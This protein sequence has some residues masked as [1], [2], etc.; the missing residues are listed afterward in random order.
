MHEV[1]N[2]E[3]IKIDNEPA[4]S[5]EEIADTGDEGYHLTASLKDIRSNI[6]LSEYDLDLGPYCL[7]DGYYDLTG[8][9]MELGY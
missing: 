6:T 5:L 2:M 1:K 7:K 3:Y 8:I 4:M 9:L